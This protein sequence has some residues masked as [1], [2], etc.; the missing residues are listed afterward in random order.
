LAGC[1]LGPVSCK[2][3]LNVEPVDRLS[4]ASFWKT[5]QD[6]ESAVADAYGNIFERLTTGPYHLANGDM[7]P[8]DLSWNGGPIPCFIA[9]GENDLTDAA[10]INDPSRYGMAQ[11][12]DWYP[13]YQSIASCNIDIDRVTGVNAL[14]KD[15][16]KTYS[17][18]F[19]FVRAFTYFYISRL[20]GDVPLYTAPYDKSALPRSPMLDVMKFCL[21][22]CEAIKDDLPW[23]YSD[24]ANW[25][26]RA[27]RG[28]IY[29]LMA[30]INMWMAGFDKS[31]QQKYWQAAADEVSAIMNSGYFELLPISEYHKIFKGRTKESL[32]EFSV[33]T[34]YGATTMY[35]SAGQWM[36]HSPIID[37]DISW[38]WYKSSYMEKIYPP[39]QPDK[40]R[41][42]WFYL[43]YANNV[44]TMFL[45]YSNV[46]DPRSGHWLFDDNLIVFRYGGILLLG[47]EAMADLGQNAEA[48]RLLNMVRKRAEA[49]LYQSSDD[50]LKEFIFQ[51]R[52]RELI[53]EG[54]RWYDLVRTERVMDPNECTDYLTSAQFNAGAW[55]WP[56]DPKARINNPNITLNSY[57][58][59]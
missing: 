42:L 14:S 22:E 43:P 8:G 51:E 58:T 4:D 21:S 30:N 17:A 36:T 37:F 55:T 13:F 38:A 33:N 3:F 52:N 23:Q 18:E 1:I 11:L 20:Y 59:K 32:F 28:S 48:I 54:V 56:I 7:R 12:S 46:S 27:S 53:G 10:R 29:A 57:W 35:V 6:V 15:E 49:S 44:Q 34:N 5:K 9:V 39:D 31:N 40:R 25:G 24:P 41:D 2:K 26:V 50:K 16:I 45:K 47:A 19:R